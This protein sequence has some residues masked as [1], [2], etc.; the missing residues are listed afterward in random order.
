MKNNLL[1]ISVIIFI[2]FQGFSQT[3]PMPGAKWTYC[4]TG[5]NGM[6]A[7]EKM[8]RVTSD[9]LIAGK[10]YSIIN[11]INTDDKTLSH[12]LF[13]R[14][15]NDTVYRYVNNQEYLFFTY[16]LSVGD[17]FSTF[18]TAGWNYHWEDSAC[19][20]TLTLKVI[21]KSEIELDGQILKKFILE[22]TLFPYLYDPSYPDPI[23]YILIE[24][25]GVI[26]SYQL[27]NTIEVPNS[28]FL[29]TDWSYPE[30]GEYSDDNFQYLFDECEG[31]GTNE[32]L[33]S[34]NDILVYPNPTVSE[35]NIEF[36][37]NSTEIYTIDIYSVFGQ[38]I[39][40]IKTNKN[41]T[42]ID[43]SELDKGIYFIVIELQGKILRQKI[44][45]E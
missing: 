17:Y 26:N 44:I 42:N 25:I 28:C 31:V 10:I 5:W 29:P 20:S 36:K 18:R 19:T 32:I 24:R 3:W 14:Y 21:E 33:E 30:L 38:K 41:K 2:G 1:L 7:G 13:T 22:D 43:I 40:T 8:F 45:K 35:I 39:K 16:N 34:T 27:I 23:T 4:I 12:V 37:T 15:E 11:S 6:P 9:T